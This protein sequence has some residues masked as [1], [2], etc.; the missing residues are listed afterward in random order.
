VVAVGCLALPGS[1]A[2]NAV[3]S[4]PASAA[5]AVVRRLPFRGSFLVTATWGLPTGPNHETPAIDFKM[6]IGTPV[7]ATAAGAVDFVSVDNRNCNPLTHIPPGGTY[8]DAIQWCIDHG[9]NGTRIRIRH[10]DGTFSMYVHLSRIRTGISAQAA[11]R[12]TAG[13]VIGWSGNSGIS[14]GPHLHY[15]KINAAGTATVDPGLLRGCW[16]ATRHDYTRINLLRGTYVRN[17]NFTCT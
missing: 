1:A 7:F 8:A 11:T 12:V 6:P 14:T 13:E 16:N 9:L 5:V 17:D 2:L 10:D 4:P 15:S 3:Q